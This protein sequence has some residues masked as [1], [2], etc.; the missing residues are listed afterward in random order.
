MLL[1]DDLEF[2]RQLV[3]ADL[4]HVE[5]VDLLRGSAHVEVPHAVQ[6]SAQAVGGLV[7]R[8]QAKKHQRRN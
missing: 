8:H 7:S 5:E 2:V 4:V 6:L 3:R 1:V